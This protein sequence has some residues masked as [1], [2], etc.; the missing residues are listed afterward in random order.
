MRFLIERELNESKADLQKFNQYFGP[1]LVKKFY[2]YKDR[3][4][5]DDRDLYA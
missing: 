3:I 2:Q 4:P 5:K 1:V